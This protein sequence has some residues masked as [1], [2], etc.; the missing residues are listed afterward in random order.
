LNDP[1]ST[2]LIPPIFVWEPR[3]LVVFP[4][5]DD[6]CRYVEPEDVGRVVGFDS[7]GTKFHFGPAAIPVTAFGKKLGTRRGV[8]VDWAQ[9]SPSREA[10]LKEVLQIALTEVGRT[11]NSEASLQDLIG[12]ANEVF[13]FR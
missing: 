10:E 8:S 5:I 11:F 3:D 4:T 13:K 1:I 12:T 2:K 9:V 7:A 6:A